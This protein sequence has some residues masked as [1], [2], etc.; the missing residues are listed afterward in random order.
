[1]RCSR[2]SHAGLVIANAESSLIIDPGDFTSTTDLRATLAAA[3]AIAAIVITHE[4]QDHWTPE[5]IA[6][7]LDHSPNASIF[8][9][10]A[11][12]EAIERAAVTGASNISVNVVEE[13]DIAEAGGFTLDFYGRRHEV[14]HSSLPVVE[15]IGVFV[16]R[17]LA[18]GGDSLARPPFVTPVLGIPV[19]SPWSNV[20]QVMDFVLEA[21]PAFAFTTHDGMLSERGLGLYTARVE[22]CLAQSGGKLLRFP[23]AS[24][25]PLT[26]LGIET[27]MLEGSTTEN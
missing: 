26:W 1:M 5:H 4:H 14:I 17:T 16:N 8:T 2:L 19:G 25:V 9:T 20:A 6:S 18:W 13:G 12:A 7:I 22:A 11:T 21:A 24:D 3:P 10:K 23:R 15:N 27:A